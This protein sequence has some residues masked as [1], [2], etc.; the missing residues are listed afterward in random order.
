VDRAVEGVAR[1][2]HALRSGSGD[3]LRVALAT[4]TEAAQQDPAPATLANLGVAWR[5][6]HRWGLARTASSKVSLTCAAPCWP[7]R[8]TIRTTRRAPRTSGCCCA[9]STRLFPGRKRSP[10]RSIC[11]RPRSAV[12]DEQAAFGQRAE[13]A[14]NL[15]ITLQS[16]YEREHRR[17][18]LDEAVRLGRLAVDPAVRRDAGTL[19]SAWNNLAGLLG[20]AFA[21]SALLTD[22]DEAVDA[23]DRAAVQLPEQ[24]TM[25]SHYLVTAGQL[26]LLRY[27]TVAAP[28]DRER[29]LDLLRAAV[30]GC[31]PGA[32]W[33]AGAHT[34][35]ATALFRGSFTDEGGGLEAVIGHF[36]AAVEAT[37]PDSAGYAGRVTNLATALAERFLRTG[38]R[39]SLDAAMRLH[40]AAVA[41]PVD[42]LA[43][44]AAVLTS[45]AESLAIRFQTDGAA[46]DAQLAVRLARQAVGLAGRRRRETATARIILGGVL[47]AWVLRSGDPTDLGECVDQ[48]RQ[49]LAAS[50]AVGAERAALEELSAALLLR[51][52]RLGD[53][54]D[55]DEAIAAGRRL[56]ALVA[57]DDLRRVDALARLTGAL[58]RRVLQDR[59]RDN[60]DA[61]VEAARQALV[62]APDDATASR[63]TLATVLAAALRERAALTASLTDLEEAGDLITAEAR[64]ARPGSFEA[65]TRLCDLGTVLRQRAVRTDDPDLLDAAVDAHRQA[66]RAAGPGTRESATALH[67]LAGSLRDRYVRSG[68]DRDLVQALALLRRAAAVTAAPAAQRLSSARTCAELAAATER[69]SIGAEAYATAIALLRVTLWH[70]VDRRQLLD[71]VDGARWMTADAAAAA[72]RADDVRGALRV[73]E[74]G[75][76]L[77]WRQR[78]E[79][80]TSLRSA[81]DNP[82]LYDRLLAA[83][84]VLDRDPDLAEPLLDGD[85]AGLVHGDVTEGVRRL[86]REQRMAAARTWDEAAGQL[87]PSRRATRL[88]RS[89]TVVLLLVSRYRNYAILRQRH[90][91]VALPLTGLL[92]DELA[93]VLT[94]YPSAADPATDPVR[95]QTVLTDTLAW[96]WRVVV[97]PVLGELGHGD[98]CRHDRATDRVW[99]C[100]TGPLALFPLHAAGDALDHVVSSYTPTIA[101]LRGHPPADQG[102]EARLLAV[103]S[104]E[105][106]QAGNEI[107]EIG[108]RLAGLAMI[109]TMDGPGATPDTVLEALRSHRLAHLICHGEQDTEQPSRAGLR[110]ADGLLT[111]DDLARARLAPSTDLVYLAACQTAWPGLR[112]YDEALHLAAALFFTGCR[113]VIATLW[114]IADRLG[115]LAAGLVYGQ[116]AGHGQLRVD[117]CAQA[118]HELVVALR[119]RYAGAPSL[120]APFVHYGR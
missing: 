1:L 50:R 15:A 82:Q 21:E 109:D 117:D 105:L 71:R 119:R 43:D 108:S 115:P 94:A 72:L 100:A 107:A 61:A 55:L 106:P 78:V 6:A 59:T 98:A 87:V 52:D 84:A 64:R 99:W 18:D 12:R 8:P 97:A 45:Y 39:D 85:L 53:R 60:A 16:R 23:A 11:C 40:E 75:R 114:P 17:D 110:L 111:V 96:L 28:A 42:D 70:G 49:A 90:R 101:A 80:D 57:P 91:M 88:P 95:A 46:P 33:F 20:A 37:D 14:G 113:H 29:A 104:G 9:T 19:A 30:A 5:T 27:D 66:L 36:A 24:H 118:L 31:P 10:R 3:A 76:T 26:H 73:L 102:V 13:W 116:L 79:A 68:H 112:L 74:N 92:L 63:G 22:L 4:L 25:H 41:A 34:A 32:R 58:R 77:L 62:A 69:W 67:N 48:L 54:E 120:W 47:R 2:R 7:P 44:W 38:D 35:L 83:R 81:A 86:G 93:E 65:T 103:D 56:L 51:Y 89:G